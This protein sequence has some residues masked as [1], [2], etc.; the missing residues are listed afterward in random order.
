MIVTLHRDAASPW[1]W[2]RVLESPP[3]SS[4]QEREGDARKSLDSYK[5]SLFERLFGRAQSRRA[6]LEA[7]VAKARADDEATWRETVEQWKWYQQ[8]AAG[9]RSK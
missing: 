4:S 1:D 7:A 2:Q 5:P 6:E 3:P 9:N 8:L